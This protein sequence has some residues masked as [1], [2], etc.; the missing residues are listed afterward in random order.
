MSFV[1]LYSFLCVLRDILVVNVKSIKNILSY[2]SIS[3]VVNIFKNKL[4]SQTSKQN[5]I[6]SP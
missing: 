5:R 6:E 3:S 2:H 4:K 1:L